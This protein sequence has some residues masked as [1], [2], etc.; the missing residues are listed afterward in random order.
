MTGYFLANPRTNALTPVDHALEVALADPGLDFV[1]FSGVTIPEVRP[2]DE[3]MAR[4]VE[5]RVAWLGKRIA[6]APIPVIPVGSTCVD[7]SGYSR[8]LLSQH[9]IHL[10]GGIDLGVRA[11]GNALRWLERRGT[12]AVRA[13]AAPVRASRGHRLFPGP[14]PRLATCSR[15]VA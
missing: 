13:A 2:P 7:V 12:V 3:G 14:K 15:P 1:L 4:M 11:L 6:T 5:E 9:R 8:E 10:L